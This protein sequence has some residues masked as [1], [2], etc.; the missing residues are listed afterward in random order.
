M[1]EIV[2]MNRKKERQLRRKCALMRSEIIF[3]RN[4][5]KKFNIKTRHKFAKIVVGKTLGYKHDYSM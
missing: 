3:R 2:E 4:E 5:P 1:K